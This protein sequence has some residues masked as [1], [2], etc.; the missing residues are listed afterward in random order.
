MTWYLL[1]AFGLYT[2]LFHPFFRLFI[3][4]NI[5]RSLRT[6]CTC[7]FTIVGNRIEHG[8]VSQ[9]SPA[10]QSMSCFCRSFETAKIAVVLPWESEEL[11]RKM[12]LGCGVHV[13]G[14]EQMD[15][16]QTLTQTL[17]QVKRVNAKFTVLYTHSHISVSLLFISE[18][19]IKWK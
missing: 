6:G 12:Y 4:A 11:P 8:V 13:S 10:F 18:R 5:L 1:D 19:Y 14:L 7:W 9:P 2:H 17:I 16:P 15:K 3:F